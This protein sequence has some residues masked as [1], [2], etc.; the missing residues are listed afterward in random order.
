MPR[1][2]RNSVKFT[3]EGRTFLATFNHRH[4]DESRLV[5]DRV[6][7]SDDVLA[8]KDVQRVITPIKVGTLRLRHIT[9]CTIFG[10]DSRS[11]SLGVGEAHCSVKDDYNWRRGLKVALT[12][13]IESM[14][15]D[16]KAVNTGAFL[17]AFY[18]ELPIRQE[19]A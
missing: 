15:V 17:G 3:V 11:T 1:L 8:F 7:V 5:G 6:V 13:A 9:K 10:G 19:T 12:R 18:R 2:T 14:V 4:C 16:G